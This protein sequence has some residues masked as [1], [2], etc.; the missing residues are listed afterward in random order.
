MAD[1]ATLHPKPYLFNASPT[2]I[3]KLGHD[4]VSS[5]RKL[6]KSVGWAVPTDSFKKNATY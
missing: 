4:L 6:R 5:S 3:G 2:W 1:E